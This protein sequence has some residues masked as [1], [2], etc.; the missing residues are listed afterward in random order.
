MISSDDYQI[1]SY[2]LGEEQEIVEL[3]SEIFVE[4]KARGDSAIDHW[5]WKYQD[6]PLGPQFVSVALKD[7]EIVGV[8]HDLQLYVKVGDDFL[9]PTLPEALTTNGVESGLVE[10]STTIASPAPN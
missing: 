9:I 4:W 6:T 7:D 1:R 2:E 5:R 10:S 8:S 3:L